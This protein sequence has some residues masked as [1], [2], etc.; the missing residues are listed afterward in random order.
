MCSM[1]DRRL[2][3]E[4]GR[5]LV[6]VARF[7]TKVEFQRV[8]GTLPT[9]SAPRWL[10]SIAARLMHIDTPP[11]RVRRPHKLGFPRAALGA[12][13]NN[14][15]TLVS[16]G[17]ERHHRLTT[18]MTVSRRGW[19]SEIATPLPSPIPWRRRRPPQI[20]PHGLGGL[21]VVGV[22]SSSRSHMELS[23]GSDESVCAYQ[24]GGFREHGCGEAF[25]KL[26]RIA[27][28]YR[29]GFCFYL[30]SRILNQRSTGA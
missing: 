14:S 1:S 3:D 28:L 11:N 8:S 19:L 13:D 5:R 22:R 6:Q 23:R 29:C 27:L 20:T 24:Q 21:L 12:L 9:L 4:W 30:N 26:G 16:T 18:P 7:Q 15:T 25:M 2:S 10:P 17:H